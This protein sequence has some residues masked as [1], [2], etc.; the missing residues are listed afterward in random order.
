[1]NYFFLIYRALSFF[2]IK[3]CANFECLIQKDSYGSTQIHSF[4]NICIKLYFSFTLERWRTLY[5]TSLSTQT[6]YVDKTINYE[7]EII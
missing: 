4:T 5:T 6:L 3:Q 2:V 7:L 1:M